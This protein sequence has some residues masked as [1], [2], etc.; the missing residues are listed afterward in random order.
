MSK[1][2][3]YQ[4]ISALLLVGNIA[5]LLFIWQTGSYRPPKSPKD[6]I[7]TKLDLSK[8]QLL[9][10]ENLIKAHQ[11][12]LKGIDEQIRQSKQAMFQ[13]MAS[14]SEDSIEVHIKELGQLQEEIER[15]NVKHFTSLKNLCTEDQLPLFDELT[16]DL[17][18]L[19]APGRRK[20]P[21]HKA[22]GK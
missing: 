15:I 13:S 2:R 8:E 9:R 10:Y 7:A 12:E 19:L 4:L 17:D 6:I 16:E 14:S 20:P 21:H 11:Q 5:L 1:I 22:P 3:L 18:K